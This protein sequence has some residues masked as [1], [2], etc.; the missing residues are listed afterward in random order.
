MYTDR[1]DG[2]NIHQTTVGPAF[3]TK[4]QSRFLPLYS[5]LIYFKSSE[6]SHHLKTTT[7]LHNFA[8]LCMMEIV[9][10]VTESV[11]QNYRKLT[12]RSRHG[13]IET[14]LRTFIHGPSLFVS[15]CAYCLVTS[16][17]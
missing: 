11:K 1:I 17:I 6:Q 15:I 10:F 8:K 9:F 13:G 2:F 16:P 7:Y 12:T 4:Y 3:L 14:L 5:Y